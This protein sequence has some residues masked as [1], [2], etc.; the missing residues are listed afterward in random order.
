[1][2]VSVPEPTDPPP[3]QPGALTLRVT[4][5]GDQRCIELFGELDLGGVD[6]LRA[7]VEDAA[8]ADEA[9]VVLDMSALAFMDSSGLRETLL[10]EQRL[11]Q[12]GKTVGILRG[13]PT[14]HRVFELTGADRNLPFLEP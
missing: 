7:A 13:P 9:K 10:S 3:R 2:T 11:R 1:V 14:V 5:A 4:L 8:E 12:A 6:T